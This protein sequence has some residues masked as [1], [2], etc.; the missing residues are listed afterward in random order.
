MTWVTACCPV[1]GVVVPM[2]Q[3]LAYN[4]G[5]WRPDVQVQIVGDATDF[6]AHLWAHQQKGS[7]W[8]DTRTP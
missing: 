6:V 2:F 4:R 1:C 3:V 8:A 7:Q 5:R